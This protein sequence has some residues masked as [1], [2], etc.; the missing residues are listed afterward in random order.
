VARSND[1]PAISVIIPTWNRSDLVCRC[2]D[3]LSAQTFADVEWI[4]VD[5]GSTDDTVDVVTRGFP[6]ARVVSMPDNRGFAVATNAGIRAANGAWLFLLNND[7]TLEP[8]CL[9]RLW[10]ARDQADMLAPLVL[11][12]GDRET[13]YSAGDRI[14]PDG[15]PESWGFRAARGTFTPPPRVFGVS[16][17]AGLFRREVFERVGALE[18]SFG[19]YFEDADLCFRARLAG[20]TAAFAGDAVAYHIGSASIQGRTW[21]RS[22]QCY[23]NHGLLVIRNMPASLLLR[24]GPAILRERIHQFGRAFSAVRTEL[25]AAR[26]LVRCLG[27]WLSLC[28]RLPRAIACRR[29]IQGMRVLPI[30]DLRVL[31]EEG[32]HG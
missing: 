7:M 17:G 1:R 23:R 3:S 31:L 18:E 27:A 26:A 30:A 19:A 16:A 4:V 13:I 2:L 10:A 21:W 25:G 22:V 20:F 9:A 8:N 24:H 29:R 14:A 6:R 12:D 11:W 5:D 15:R 32:K 28:A